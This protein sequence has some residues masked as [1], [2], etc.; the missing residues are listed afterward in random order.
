MLRFAANPAIAAHF[1][2]TVA[3]RIVTT[4]LPPDEIARYSDRQA[5]VTIEASRDST[6]PVRPEDLRAV[7]NLTGR[8][9]G[10]YAIPLTIVG[11]R[12]EVKSIVPNAETL[13]IERVAGRT[14]QSVCTMSGDAHGL[15]ATKVGVN[16]QSATVRGASDDLSKVATVRAVLAFPAQPQ[17]VATQWCGWFPSTSAVKRLRGS[18]CHRT[19]RACAPTSRTARAVKCRASSV[20]TAFAGLRMPILPLSLR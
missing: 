16:P 4:G 6:T 15:V 12:L 1:D 20:P 9:P 17:R 13:E 2:Q 18:R 10:V 19:T 11:L 5:I 14:R 8:G 3:V 7:L